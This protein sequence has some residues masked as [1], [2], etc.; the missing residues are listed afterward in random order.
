MAKKGETIEVHVPR[1]PASWW[2]VIR[3]LDGSSGKR[4]SKAD[5]VERTGGD[6][7]LV[8]R[9]ITR[10]CAAG[11]AEPAEVQGWFRLIRRPAQ[12]PVL[13]ASGAPAAPTGQ[14]QMWTA[15]RSLKSFNY[16]EL[17]HAASTDTRPVNPSTAKT[18]ANALGRAGYLAMIHP[19]RPGV[20]TIW[21]LKPS[22]NTGPHAPMIMRTKF[23]WDQNRAEVV[24][25]AEKAEEVRP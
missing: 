17:A 15:I 19:G 7:P 6:K 23:V 14:Q 11:I 4:W 8:G 5:V 10:L 3:A 21:R 22:M 13:D 2:P 24:G 16:V 1:G 9:Y 18:Y 25:P 20:P 12:P